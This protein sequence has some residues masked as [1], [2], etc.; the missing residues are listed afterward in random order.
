[1]DS[2]FGLVRFYVISTIV[3]YLMLNPFH[4][5]DCPL[6][7]KLGGGTRAEEKTIRDTAC[8]LC[9]KGLDMPYDSY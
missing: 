7:R 2:Y 3:G 5:I 9:G 4:R 1:M 8:R 6:G